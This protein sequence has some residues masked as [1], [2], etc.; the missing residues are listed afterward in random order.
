MINVQEDI[1]HG[2]IDKWIVQDLYQMYGR[3]EVLETYR[4]RNIEDVRRKFNELSEEVM[5]KLP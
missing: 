5:G 3:N 4:N 2:E 1:L